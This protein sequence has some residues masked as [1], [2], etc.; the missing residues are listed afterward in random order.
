[1]HAFALRYE[2]LEEMEK[3]NKRKIYR[4]ENSVRG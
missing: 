3:D 4:V 1:M 2:I